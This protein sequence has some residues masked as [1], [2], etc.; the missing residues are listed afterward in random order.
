M[1]FRR[2]ARTVFFIAVDKATGNPVTTG[3][4][5]RL[6]KDGGASTATINNPTF[7]S[8]CTWAVALTADEMDALTL[9]VIPVNAS[10]S[11]IPTIISTTPDSRLIWGYLP[12]QTGMLANQIKLAADASAATD[13]YKGNSLVVHNSNGRFALSIVAYNGAT[14][15][16]TLGSNKPINPALNN[17]YHVVPD[18]KIA[19]TSADVQAAIMDYQVDGMKFSDHMKLVAA[20]LYGQMA[21]DPDGVTVRFRDIQNTKARVTSVTTTDGQRTSVS[22]D[23]T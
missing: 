7:I 1:F 20:T 6:S 19:M 9:A 21:I 4:T 16:A 17:Y 5:A 11:G 23:V 22:R 3:V 12:D 15:V 18:G 14:K 10:I 2:E 8:G 13:A